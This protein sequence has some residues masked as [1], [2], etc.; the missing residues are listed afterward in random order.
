MNESEIRLQFF[1]NFDKFYGISL[2]LINAVFEYG[3][4]NK[5]FDTIC[6]STLW[7]MS[8]FNYKTGDLRILLPTAYYYYKLATGVD[9][10]CEN[11]FYSYIGIE[12]ENMLLNQISFNLKYNCQTFANSLDLLLRFNI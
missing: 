11:Y 8:N 1:M 10:L 3:G 4:K 2:D 12:N 7:P 5:M 6:N 9:I